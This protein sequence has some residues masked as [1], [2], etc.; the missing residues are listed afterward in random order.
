MKPSLPVPESQTPPSGLW[1]ISLPF[2]IWMDLQGQIGPMD[3]WK[4]C[5]SSFKNLALTFSERMDPTKD[6][7]CQFDEFNG[8]FSKYFSSPSKDPSHDFPIL[9]EKA[10]AQE[11][12]QLIYSELAHF[13]GFE[14]Q[15]VVNCEYALMKFDFSSGPLLIEFDSKIQILERPRIMELVNQNI[16]FCKLDNGMNKLIQALKKLRLAWTQDQQSE[17][18]CVLNAAM[19]KAEPYNLEHI[20]KRA[21]IAFNARDYVGAANDIRNYFTYKSPEIP[22]STL[23]KIYRKALEEIQ[24][25]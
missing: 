16:D 21:H 4:K 17:K 14:H 10:N 8:I 23:K 1:N 15:F 18:L 9:L 12:L 6:S 25:Q 19:I 20:K 22:A 24:A 13:F 7:R 11:A 2:A 3:S 5:L